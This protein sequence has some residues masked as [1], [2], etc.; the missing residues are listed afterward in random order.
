MYLNPQFMQPAAYK[1]L[2]EL[3]AWARANQQLLC[4]PASFCRGSG[5]TRCAAEQ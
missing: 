2:A 1:F 3:V 5:K 4:P